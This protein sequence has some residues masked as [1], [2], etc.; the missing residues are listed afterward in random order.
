MQLFKIEKVDAE[1]YRQDTRRS[2]LVVIACFVVLALIGSLLMV[3]LFGQSGGDNFRWNLIG[4]LL[5]VLVT[6][7]LV[8]VVFWQQAWMASAVY[9]WRLRRALMRVTNVMHEVKAGVTANNSAAI[10]LLRF[11]HLGVMQMHQLDANTSESTEI[12]QEINEHRDLMLKLNIELDQSALESE[13]F[14][15]LKQK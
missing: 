10:K 9:G 3:A 4:V 6:A 8:R 5:G 14:D 12:V 15:T 13:W 7:V 1:R 11:Y 2:T